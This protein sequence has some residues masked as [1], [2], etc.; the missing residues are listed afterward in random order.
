M[1]TFF[2]LTTVLYRN[3]YEKNLY[4]T[5][6][7]TFFFAW[8]SQL[9]IY[10][11]PVSQITGH[12]FFASFINFSIF[13]GW[14]HYK[15]V[16]KMHFI[17]PYSNLGHSAAIIANTHYEKLQENLPEV[18]GSKFVTAFSRNRSLKTCLYQPKLNK[19]LHLELNTK[20][21]NTWI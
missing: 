16:P 20:L 5:I 14:L 19:I 7:N 9:T 2:A 6:F 15:D 1:F 12:N 18:F 10:F 13:H 21:V 3:V 17:V 8:I 11:R 4:F